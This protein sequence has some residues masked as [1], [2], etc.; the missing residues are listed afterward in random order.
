[1]LS[2]ELYTQLLKYLQQKEYKQ[3]EEIVGKLA[4]DTQGRLS[5][6]LAPILY[7]QAFTALQRPRGKFGNN[8]PKQFPKARE[9]TNSEDTTKQKE[10]LKLW[11]EMKKSKN[12]NSSLVD[13]WS[14]FARARIDGPKAVSDQWEKKDKPSAEEIWN[15]AVFYTAQSDFKRGLEVLQSILGASRKAREGVPFTRLRF[16]LYCAVQMLD[17]QPEARSE[18]ID[19]LSKHLN[20]WPAPACVLAWIL[21]EKQGGRF[22]DDLQKQSEIWKPLL[23]LLKQQQAIT[24]PELNK[25]P[26]D[27]KVE[28]FVKQLKN[29]LEFYETLILWLEEYTQSYCAKLK[30]FD[31]KMRRELSEA[32][33][34]NKN[35]D[36]AGQVLYEIALDQSRIFREQEKRSTDLSKAFQPMRTALQELFM[37]YERHKFLERNDVFEKFKKLHQEVPKLWDKEEKRNNKLIKLTEPLLKKLPPQQPQPNTPK[38]QVGLFLDYENVVRGK[39]GQKLGEA[40]IKY[41]SQFGEVV[42]RWASADP[43]NMNGARFKEPLEQ[44]GFKVEFPHDALQNGKAR[45]N[46]ADHTLTRLIYHECATTKPNIYIIVSGDGGYIEYVNDLLN[47]GATVRLCASRPNLAEGYLALAEKRCQERQAKGLASDFFIDDLDNVCYM[48]SNEEQ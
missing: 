21:L 34:S 26:E 41:A 38:K 27:S 1:L 37:F 6:A 32:Y 25:R 42:C 30:M 46:A 33:E 11:E 31:T 3:L 2:P 10:G 20:K 14:L 28:E 12:G 16:A 29:Q 7:D 39:D 43:R 13:E 40:L 47:H 8:G 23:W 44:V 9:F 17:Q 4:S 19:V 22:P 18:A 15:L 35:L 45:K 5:P 36:R 48:E 24:I